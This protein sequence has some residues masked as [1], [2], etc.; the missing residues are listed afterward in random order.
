[1][2]AQQGHTSSSAPARNVFIIS[3]RFE[4]TVDTNSIETQSRDFESRARDIQRRSQESLPITSRRTPRLLGRTVED[5]IIT[6]N[7]RLDLAR[8]QLVRLVTC[9]VPVEVAVGESDGVA[10]IVVEHELQSDVAGRAVVVAD[11]VVSGLNSVFQNQE[12]DGCGAER[13]SKSVDGHRRACL[14]SAL[15][16]LTIRR[17]VCLTGTCSRSE[18]VGH[19]VV[20]D[21]VMADGWRRRMTWSD[22]TVY[23]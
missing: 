16:L 12:G 6:S 3:S 20:I 22:T 4:G 11:A 5:E 8:L 19:E 15:G 14:P 2:I 13:R 7:V 17:V 18:V 10:L 1:M 21:A 23:F 9:K